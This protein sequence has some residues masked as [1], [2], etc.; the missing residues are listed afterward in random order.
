MLSFFGP[1]MNSLYNAYSRLDFAFTIT[2]SMG[3][4]RSTSSLQVS[5][6]DKGRVK[7]LWWTL[8]IHDAYCAV[9]PGR[10]FR[11][12]I[13]QCDVVMLEL[14]DFASELTDNQNRDSA[15]Y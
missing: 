3:I 13:P 15:L 2:E 14:E 8:A 1:Q 12:D 6:K 9:P 5:S 11:I 7:R 4:H 10:P